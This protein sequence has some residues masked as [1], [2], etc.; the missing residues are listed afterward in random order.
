[1]SS[2]K[3]LCHDMSYY[4]SYIASS[5]STCVCVCVHVCVGVHACMY[6][7]KSTRCH[8]TTPT[9]CFARETIA[10]VQNLGLNEAQRKD[11]TTIIEAMQR[12][13]DGHVSETVERRNLR[14]RVQMPEESFDDFLISL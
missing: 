9:L 10:I 5:C 8:M 4:D 13:V 7:Y 12:Y 3:F 11:A 6:D 2:A 14:R 1:M